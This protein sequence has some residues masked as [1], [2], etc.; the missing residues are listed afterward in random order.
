LYGIADGC[1][2]LSMKLLIASIAL[3]TASLVSLAFLPS[4]AVRNVSLRGNLWVLHF[5]PNRVVFIFLFLAAIA[6]FLF[7]GFDFV[8]RVR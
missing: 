7:A 8:V 6:A 3:F 2:I 1:S 5:H 4:Y